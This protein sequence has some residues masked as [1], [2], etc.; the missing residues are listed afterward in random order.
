MSP[1]KLT[2]LGLMI[3]GCALVSGIVG[4]LKF[5]FFGIAMGVLSAIFYG[6]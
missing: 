6:S 2:A 5:N 4:G 3:L 1:F